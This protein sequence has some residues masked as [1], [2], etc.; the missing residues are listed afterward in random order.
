VSNPVFVLPQTTEHLGW[1]GKLPGT[2]DFAQR[3]LPSRFVSVWD[4]WLQNGFEYLRFA[5]TDWAQSYLE[6]HI[7]FFALG[8][9][10]IGPKPWLGV[11]LPSVDSVGRYFPL[12]IAVELD[13]ENQTLVDQRG[14]R[15]NSEI[16]AGLLNTCARIALQALDEDH[17]AEGF[18]A[19]LLAALA[20]W[21]SSAKLPKQIFVPKAARS[22]WHIGANFAL[23]HGFAVG[24]MPGNSEFSLLFASA[25]EAEV[26]LKELAR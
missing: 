4:R 10:V 7:W 9:S 6:G 17:D 3:R 22:S 20:I 15:V 19:R 5:K 23:D 14:D 12:T 1:Y 18:D 24:G 26:A 21:Q 8:P 16:V 11:L 25:N 2:G 13:E